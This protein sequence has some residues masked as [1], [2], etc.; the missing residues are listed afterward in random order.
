MTIH[1]YAMTC[2]DFIKIGIAK[3]VENRNHELRLIMPFEVQVVRD[4]AY[5]KF[6]ITG[7]PP[8]NTALLVERALH[9]NLIGLGLHHRGEW[10]NNIKKTLAV[11]DDLTTKW[12]PDY[13]LSRT[14]KFIQVVH[15]IWNF[16]LHDRR[17]IQKELGN[18]GFYIIE[19]FKKCEPRQLSFLV[20]DNIE[21][22][23]KLLG[24]KHELS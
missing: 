1:I 4:I 16:N 17:K 20:G 5:Q 10:F 11:Y 6:G 9:E 3:N 2:G 19:R 24:D 13:I 8:I 18:D 12:N 22:I 15:E 14:E 21:R 23:Q 7:R